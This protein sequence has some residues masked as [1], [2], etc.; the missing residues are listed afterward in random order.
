V[1]TQRRQRGLFWTPANIY[2]IV[3]LV[4]GMALL[5]VT[6]LPLMAWRPD[7]MLVVVVIWSLQRGLREG[8]VWAFFGGALMDLLSAGPF[9][10]FTLAL[11]VA[12]LVAGLAHRAAFNAWLLRVSVLALA[13]FLYHVVY[14]GVMLTAGYGRWATTSQLLG[15]ALGLNLLL[16]L[17]LYRPLAWANRRPAG[18]DMNW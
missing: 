16:F 12:A 1:A 10:A 4:I 7:L 5:H 3:A 6:W 8:L 9:G 15:P 14:L 17:L 11:L 2:L 13:T 18:V